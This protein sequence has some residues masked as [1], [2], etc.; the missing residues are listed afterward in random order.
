M[1]S[2]DQ[3]MAGDVMNSL[4]AT[5]AALAAGLV[6]AADVKHE[7]RG[8][9]QAAVHKKKKTAQHSCDFF[10]GL[11]NSGEFWDIFKPWQRHFWKK[12]VKSHGKNLTNFFPPKTR[13]HFQ[14]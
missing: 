6:G 12:Q 5:L 9:V 3:I 14:F 1:M 2:M 7:T 13:A 8:G 10:T 11:W 4:V